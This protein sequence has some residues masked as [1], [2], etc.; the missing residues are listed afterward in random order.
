[1]WKDLEENCRGLLSVKS[2]HLTGRTEE[3]HG[4]LSQDSSVPAE[5]RRKTPNDTSIGLY[6]YGNPL[7]EV[8]LECRE[9]DTGNF[10]I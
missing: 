10:V 7:G 1:M 2:R 3:N 8:C 9:S 6:R 4:N 5:I